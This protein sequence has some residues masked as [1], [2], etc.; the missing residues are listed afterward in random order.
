MRLRPHHLLCTQSYE[1]KGYSPAFIKNMTA[2]TDYL[3]NSHRPE[4]EI[5]F[6]TD[7]ICLCCP[8]KIGDDMCEQN[9]KVKR[10]DEKVTTYFSVEEEKYNYNEI[11]AKINAA[12]TVE[13]MDD[14]CGHC[15]W[16]S[17]SN[18]KE[19]IVTKNIWGKTN[20]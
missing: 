20:G 15:S 16:Y 3:R 10:M 1:G 7:D 5:V 18:C 19:T 14:I 9:D 4:I 13:M 12:M 17:A 6:T 2:I 8:K 11:T